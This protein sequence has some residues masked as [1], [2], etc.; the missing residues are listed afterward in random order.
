MKIRRAGDL[1]KG[2]LARGAPAPQGKGKRLPL[3][4]R[5]GPAR[6][7]LPAVAPV[8]AAFGYD[9]GRNWRPGLPTAVPGKG[10]PWAA[11]GKGAPWAAPGKGAPWAAPGKGAPWAAPGKGVAWPPRGTAAVPG[12]GAAGFVGLR[13]PAG[14]G[15][16]MPVAGLGK[17]KPGKVAAN[18]KTTLCANHQSGRCFAGS[19]C[20]WAH[21]EEEMEQNLGR[22]LRSLET[23]LARYKTSIC[24]RWASGLCGLGDDCTFAHGQDELEEWLP[25]GQEFPGGAAE[26]LAAAPST[27]PTEAPRT[28]ELS[29]QL[30]V[31]PPSHGPMPG[32]P[33]WLGAAAAPGTPPWLGSQ[34]AAPG[35][36]PWLGAAPGTPPSM[37]L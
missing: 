25:E 12:W 5:P 20:T 33:P 3:L 23:S 11:P 13:A 35:T 27:P 22:K 32:T 17:G 26:P 19:A 34:V 9:A 24:K 15:P 30:P 29:E 7:V 8:R 21:S 36:P 4:Q 2:G 18:Y 31:T 1:G 6:P 16:G 37:R 14:G 10:V 28:P